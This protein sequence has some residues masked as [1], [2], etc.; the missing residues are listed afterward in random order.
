MSYRTIVVH[1]A[2]DPDHKD[3]LRF[4]VDFAKRFDAHLD[5]VYTS[6]LIELP[7]VPIGRAASMAFLDEIAAENREH[8]KA[9]MG[10]SDEICRALESW[11]WHG[12]R[13]GHVEEVVERYAHVA[14]LVIAEQPTP[15]ILERPSTLRTSDFLIVAS[16][17]PMLMAPSGWLNG[18]T[19]RR[20]LIAWKNR[21]ESISAV[22]SA[23]PLLDTAETVLI[24]ADSREKV[25]DPP[26]SS[27]VLFL[28]R[29]GIRSEV[30]EVTDEGAHR[31][32][33]V[34]ARQGCDMIVMGAVGH[35]RLRN[36]I[37]GTSTDYV[38]GHTSVP[39]FMRH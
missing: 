7:A 29:H 32:V 17:C 6:D 34:A 30:C 33:E 3:R 24:L 25:A 31:I 23:L 19:G 15:E 2:D 16:G 20:I 12:V 10:E 27:L 38:M 14:D 26:G 5:V 22:R 37:V 4:A 1:I 21:P 9:V 35:S 36:L 18:D 28:K 39:V 11:R 8:I 13:Q